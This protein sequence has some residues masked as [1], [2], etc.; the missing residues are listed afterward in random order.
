[1]KANNGQIE[2]AAAKID[3]SAIHVNGRYQITALGVED[4][5]LDLK[6]AGQ[7]LLIDDLQSM[8]T[9]ADVRLPN[10]AVL[11]GG[12][13]SL[14]LSITGQ[15]KSLIV[16]GTIALDNTRLVG[17][18]LGSKIHGVAAL[19]G[20]QTGDTTNIEKLRVTVRIT[21]ADVAIEKIEAV[22]PALGEING[23]GTV[24][25]ADELDFDLLARVA[26]E[27][28]GKVGAGLLTKLNGSGG[29]SGEVSGVP[30]ARHR[31]A[32][33]TQYYCGRRRH[34][35]EKSKI[36]RCHLRQKELATQRDTDS[37]SFFLS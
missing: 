30:P 8:M 5:L 7:R 26:A 19:G 16:A 31:H 1:M 17:F 18:D 13:L 27:G 33:G 24:G 32:R 28:I 21:N 20:P 34:L 12:T 35:Q 37:R 25:A 4:P 2:D 10:G 23:S 14:D 29:A 6:I 36:P 22:I 9:A 15:V 11:K 3:A